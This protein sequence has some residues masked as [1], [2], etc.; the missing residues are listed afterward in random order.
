MRSAT[1]LLAVNVSV[2][3]IHNAV[4]FSVLLMKSHIIT[5]SNVVSMSVVVFGMELFAGKWQFEK[6][7]TGT[8]IP[9]FG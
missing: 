8:H 3:I 1:G 5:T 6:R 4:V 2:K 7:P 9:I